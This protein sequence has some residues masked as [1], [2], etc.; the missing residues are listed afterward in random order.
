MTYKAQSTEK[1]NNG[2]IGI[3]KI[4]ITKLLLE[5]IISR[6]YKDNPQNGGKYLQITYLIRVYNQNT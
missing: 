6:K 1:K 5:R 3:Y 2:Q 4:E